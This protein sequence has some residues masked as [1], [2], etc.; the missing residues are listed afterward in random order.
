[1]RLILRSVLISYASIQIAQRLV[2]GI[3]FGANPEQNM[4][5]L[6]VALVLLNLFIIPILRIL[7]LPHM[8]L[9]FIL[10]NFLLT[11]TVLYILTIFITDLSIVETT[12]PELRIFGFV[13]P[14]RLLS[15]VES[16]AASAFVLSF[17]Y[18]FFEWLCEKR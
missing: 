9:G 16:A 5:L 18:H 17:V 14:S 3:D 7:S 12:L 10:L 11:L 8:G 1:M 2:S 13:L 15:V 6:L 4:I